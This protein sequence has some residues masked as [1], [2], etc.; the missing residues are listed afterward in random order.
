VELFLDIFG[1]LSVLLAGLGRAAQCFYL[2]AVLFLLVLARPL[3]GQLGADGAAIA[4]LAQRTGTAALVALLAV[5]LVS[6][7]AHVVIL[8]GTTD[9]SYL[10]AMGGSYAVAQSVRLGAGLLALALLLSGAA[11]RGT[12]GFRLL[13]LCAAID[14]LAGMATSHAAARL[15]NQTVLYLATGLHHLGA[16]IWIGGLPAFLGS[17]NHL[18]QGS[19]LAAIARRYSAMSIAGVGAI[20]VSGILMLVFYVGSSAAMYGTAYGMMLGTKITL[21]LSLL[22]LGLGNAL[23]V[24]QLAGSVFGTLPRLKR[25]VEVE[26][27]TGISILLVAASITS[28]PP[29]IDLVEGRA[30]AA[31]ILERLEPRWPALT[32]PDK[33]SLAFYEELRQQRSDEGIGA[34]HLQAYVPGAGIPLPRNAEDIAWSEYN[35]HI[36]GIFVL[37]IGLLALL[38]KTGRAPWARHWPLLFVAMA[39]FLFLRSEAEGWPF[40]ALSLGESLRDPE[41]VQHKMFM[42][43]ICAFALFEW[44]VRAGVLTRRWASYVFPLLSAAGGTMLL[45]HSHSIANVKELLLIEMTH[46]PIAVLG[47]WAGWTRWLELRLDGTIQRVCGWAWPVLLSLVGTILLLY[48]EI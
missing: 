3:A 32:S 37:L 8:A 13:V 10:H 25:F 9:G 46:L 23:A 16:A 48:R 43:L 44:S 15:E 17:L 40:G 33:N 28:L 18:P 2:G 41:Y 36:S 14:L 19:A 30:T 27:G 47:I 4:A 42:V 35:H 45:T 39:G 11:A 34:K 31:E 22:L 38:E 7:S 24:R 21:F 26:I 6:L 20:L 1:F 12:A 29:A 5:L